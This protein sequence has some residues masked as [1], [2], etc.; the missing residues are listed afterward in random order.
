MRYNFKRKYVDKV[1][2]LRKATL[3]QEFYGLGAKLK[4]LSLTKSP[5]GLLLHLTFNPSLE[6]GLVHSIL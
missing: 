3:Q 5:E 2:W 1:Y 6:S 4:T